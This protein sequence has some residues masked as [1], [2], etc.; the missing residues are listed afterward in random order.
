MVGL[1]GGGG[2]ADGSG[3]E[4]GC[5]TS[6]LG[7]NVMTKDSVGRLLEG[8]NKIYFSLPK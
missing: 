7:Y 2:A 3:T 1:V 4:L 6:Y 5:S 8:T